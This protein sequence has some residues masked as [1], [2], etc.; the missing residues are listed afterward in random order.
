[1]RTLM[2]IVNAA[3]KNF[4]SVD[5]LEEDI[6]N[7]GDENCTEGNH[8]VSLRSTMRREKVNVEIKAL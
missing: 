6:A 7:E 3:T 5:V 4:M 1:M 2:S 8:F